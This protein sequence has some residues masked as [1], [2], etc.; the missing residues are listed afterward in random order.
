MQK[1]K[2]KPFVRKLGTIDVHL[3]ETTPVVFKDRLYRFEYVNKSYPFNTEGMPHFRFK[4]VESGICSAPF[5]RNYF[6]GSAYAENGRLF[7][8]GIKDEWSRDT[9]DVFTSGDMDKWELGG[10]LAL[11]GWSMF[12]T[13]VCK[14]RDGYVMALEIDAPK[15]ECGHPFTIRFAV[16]DDLVNWKLTP[17]ECVYSKDRYTACPTIRYLK[18]TDYYY[19]IYLEALPGWGFASYIARS[20]D[21][22]DWRRSPVNPFMMYDENDRIILNHSLPAETKRQ[23][24]NKLDINNSDVD[25]CEFN[26]NTVIYYCW[27]NQAGEEHLAEAVY[28]G[29]MDELLK[30]FFDDWDSPDDPVK[31]Q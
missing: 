10:S 27:G 5:A 17:S 24:A 9:L 1:A 29:P 19:M 23:I 25:L 28:E 11:P 30:G 31:A 6:L 14:G 18:E 21:L 8:F 16:S 4:D 26:G 7:A 20:R 12:N 3:V 22:A 13:S 15:E 2:F